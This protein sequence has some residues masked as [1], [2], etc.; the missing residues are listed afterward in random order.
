M[1]VT[2]E[3]ALQQ[4]IYDQELKGNSPKT[5]KYY[6]VTLGYFLNYIG[7]DKLVRELQLQD[8]KDYLLSLRG[9]VKMAG[10]PYKPKNDK[11]IKSVSIQTYIRAVRV[12]LNWL[13][14]EG[15]VTENLSKQFKLPKATKTTIEILSDEEI[16]VL[17]K[18]FKL[19]TEMGLRN[20]CIVALMLD[21]G[22]RR[23]EVLGL[24][25]ENLHLTQGV[26]KVHGKGDKDRIVPLGLYAKKLLL[27]YIGGYRSMPIYQTKKLFIDSTY[28]PMSD[29][30]LKQLFLRLR[31][32][33]GIERLRPHILRHTF[34]T[35]Y[36]MNGG[37]IFSLQQILGHT[38]LD[39]V[40][41]YSHLASA[42]II[43]KHKQ[44]SPLDNIES[45]RYR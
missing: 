20:A 37:D 10:H 23:S 32:K 45:A 27:K 43:H 31:D 9:K 42:Y 3:N 44:F 18:S 19:N 5:I 15:Y 38:S 22:L 35:K 30:A 12:F 6:N 13:Q 11:P 36:L 40:R 4:F 2:L 29:N 1:N 7:H 24:D 14:G 25:C 17:M 39:M 34:A 21:S 8:L 26:V 41:R 28:K 16:Q 33:S